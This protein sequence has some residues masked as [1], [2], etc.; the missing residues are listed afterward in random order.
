M[1]YQCPMLCTLVTNGLTAALKTLPLNAG[2]D[3]TVVAYSIDPSE[4]TEMAAAAKKRILAR[5]G[6]DGSAEG[7]HFLTA[8]PAAIAALSEAIGFRAVYDESLGEYAHTAGLVIATPQGEVAR[9]FFGIEFPP[10]DMR[11]SLVE[12]AE[13]TIGSVVDQVLLFCFR[14]DPATGRYS[15]LT[16]NVVRLGGLLTLGA[17]VFGIAWMVRRDRRQRDDRETVE[18]LG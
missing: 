13:G 17:M 9:Y 10:R 1:Y 4:T 12:A 14:Y 2:E 3:F 15:S 16:L 11:L 8:E 7:W 5:Y 18:T 6:R